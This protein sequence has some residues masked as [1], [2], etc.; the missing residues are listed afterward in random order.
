MV[1]GDSIHFTMSLFILDNGTLNRRD[2]IQG[3]SGRVG[4]ILHEHYK[5][6]GRTRIIF[7]RCIWLAFVSGLSWTFTRGNCNLHGVH[8]HCDSAQFYW[9]FVN[10]TAA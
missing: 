10:T 2:M 8:G 7:E 4:D 9:R 3:W 1:I 6:I 5:Y